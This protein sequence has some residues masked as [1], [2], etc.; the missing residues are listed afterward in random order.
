MVVGLCE[1]TL[2]LP[3]NRSLKGKRKVVRGLVDRLRAR[4]RIA[5]SETAENDTHDRGVVGFAVV[6]NDRRRVRA[7]LD[8]VLRTVEETCPAEVIDQELEVVDW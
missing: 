1:L 6:G 5:V 2:V 3:G 4:H 8:D 7:V